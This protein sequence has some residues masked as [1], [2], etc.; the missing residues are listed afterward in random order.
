MKDEGIRSN[1]GGWNASVLFTSDRPT[2]VW[3]GDA[4][5]AS[6][7]ISLVRNCTRNRRHL[8]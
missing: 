2:S 8:W 5:I 4:S 6:E 3:L 7:V 1:G